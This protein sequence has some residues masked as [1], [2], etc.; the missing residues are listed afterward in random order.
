MTVAIL[1]GTIA[2]SVIPTFTTVSGTAIG[3]LFGMVMRWLGWTYE[4]ELCV[5]VGQCG[6]K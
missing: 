6:C 5:G 4:W 3:V 1:Q 2:R